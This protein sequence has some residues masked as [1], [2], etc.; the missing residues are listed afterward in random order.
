[1]EALE[2]FKIPNEVEQDPKPFPY[3]QHNNP[4]TYDIKLEVS[5]KSKLKLK[6]Y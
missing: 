3:L 4:H 6:F 1:M 2:P 5:L